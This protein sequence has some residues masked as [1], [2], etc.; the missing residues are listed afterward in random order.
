MD[1]DMQRIPLR[2]A[3]LTNSISPHSIALCEAM[4]ARV[5]EF[6]IFTSA[7]A[8]SYHDFPPIQ[9]DLQIEVQ[10]S[11][12]TFRIIR[13]AYGHWQSGEL[14]IPYD[15]YARL[16]AYQP[17]VVLSLQFGVRTLFSCLYRLTHR[18]SRMIVWATLSWRTERKR[19]WLRRVVRR[20]ILRMADGAFVNGREGERYLRSLGYQGPCFTVPYAIEDGLFVNPDYNPQDDSIRL[21]Y[22]G[23]LI[24]QK[25][26]RSFC[27]VMAQWCKEHPARRVKLILAGDGRE[28]NAIR[29]L[30]LPPNF[31]I[32]ILGWVSQE[33]LAAAYK[34][35]D[36]CAFPT[37]GDEWGV[38]VNEAMIAGLPVLG[39]IHSQAALELIEEERTG[40]LFDSESEADT[41]R[42][43]DRALRA[44]ARQLREMSSQAKAKIAGF[45]PS[46]IA[47]RAL[48]SFAA[49]SNTEAAVDNKHDYAFQASAEESWSAKK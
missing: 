36:V 12:N 34:Q 40:W 35:A 48:R 1:E 32:E 25:G 21:I 46:I 14:H 31:S 30:K 43:I 13:K 8:D 38:V 45:H 28:A 17:D 7:A 22:P 18:N 47:D 26:I 20:W 41:Y 4:G 2:I 5:D 11:F 39:S 23:R 33:T 9:S 37:L 16:S 15:T 29:A 24:P 49:V 19:F 3:L 27:S 44:S 10:K 6:R 42:G